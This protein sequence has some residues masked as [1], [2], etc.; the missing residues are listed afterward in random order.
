MNIFKA[1]SQGNG[2]ITET[3][4]TSFL[5]Y[6]LNESNEFGNS[7]LIIFLENLDKALENKNLHELLNLN[8][9]NFR[10]KLKHFGSKYSFSSV[11]EY[12][13]EKDKKIR[14][15]DIFLKITDKK[16]EKDLVYF[17]IENKINKSAKDDSQ[18]FEQF[19]Y[20]CVSEDCQKNVPIYS[21][22]ITTE[23]QIFETMFNEVKKVNNKSVWLKWSEKLLNSE[24]IE[25]NIK[26]LLILE[27]NAD[28]PPIQDNSKFIL[29][30]F[31]DYIGTELSLQDKS[32]NFSVSGFE[33]IDSTEVKLGSEILNIK[34]Y[35]NNM[36]RIFDFEE[37]MLNTQVKPI[38]KRIN[39]EKNLC[40]SLKHENGI[41]KNTQTLG[42]EIIMKINNCT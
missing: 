27:N 24:S 26:K 14:I 2:Q 8:Q 35:E 33:V 30:S 39:N 29:K 32:M 1:L 21:I 41:D 7:F 34:R 10:N 11:P 40:I 16:Q 4:I 3:N 23:H 6:L 5:S 19:D 38:L 18:C 42:K 15:V 25:N 12:R 13:L 22:L 17:L 37:N 28:I 9:S 36:I 20:F 31:V